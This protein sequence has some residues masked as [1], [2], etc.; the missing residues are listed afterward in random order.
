MRLGFFAFVVLKSKSGFAGFRAGFGSNIL[1][2][3]VY[4]TYSIDRNACTVF[5]VP[6]VNA[7]GT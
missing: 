4:V 3:G 5:V 6:R 2:H 1:K 7:Q